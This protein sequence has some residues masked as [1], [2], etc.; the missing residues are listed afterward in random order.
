MPMPRLLARPAANKTFVNREQLLKVFEDACFAIPSDQAKLLVFYGIGGQG[1]TALCNELYR[2]TDRDHSYSFL[3]RCKLDLK[4]RSKTDPDLL[5]VWIRNGFAKAGIVF[6]CFDLAFTIAWD[7]TRGE[8]FMPRIESR[9]LARHKDEI[10]ETSVD[11]INALKE[12]IG[13]VATGIPVLGAMIRSIGGWTIRKGFESYLRK[14][15]TAISELYQDGELRTPHEL[16]ELL[17]WMLAQDLNHHIAT[18]PQ[19][20]FVLFIDEYERVF[21]EGGAEARWKEN[22]FDKHMRR[23]VAETD[24]LL[25]VFFSRERIPWEHDSDWQ[26]DLQ[27]AHHIVNGLSDK[28]A[29]QLLR[30]NSIEDEKLR[31]AMIE[32]ARETSASNAP[33][34]P[35]MLDLQVEHLYSLYAQ[36]S[37][38]EPD[39][40]CVASNEFEGRR[41]EL[42]E[43]LFRDYGLPLQVTLKRLCFARRFDRPAFEY[44]VRYFLTGLPLDAFETLA[45]MSF[46]TRSE[47]G[48]LSIHGVIAEAIRE[49][50]DEDTKQSSLAAL[51]AHYLNCAT[52]SSPNNIT[53]YTISSLFEA[54]Y[55]RKEIGVSG[56]VD[57]LADVT[58]PFEMASKYVACEQIWREALIFVENEL[59]TDHPDVV[60]CYLR[61]AFSLNVQKRLDAEPLI[62]RA[63]EVSERELG[64]DHPSTAK[65]YSCL[66]HSVVRKKDHSK[67]EELIR[68]ALD[69]RKRVLGE[70]HIDTAK[71]YLALAFTL[72]A[73]NREDVA[74]PFVRKALDIEKRL[75]GEDHPETATSYAVLA[76]NLI[77]QNRPQEAEKLNRKALDIRRRTLGENNPQTATSYIGL[78]SSLAKQ[79]RM[80]EA[81]PLI[82]KGLDIRANTLG[83]DH[84]DTATA[85]QSLAYNLTSQGGSVLVAEAEK[86]ICKA[87][88]IRQNILGECHPDTATAYV[89]LAQNLSIQGRTEEAET[90]ARKALDIRKRKLGN[91]HIDTADGYIGLWRNLT[92]QKKHKEAEPP[93][94]RALDIRRRILG[95]DHSETVTAMKILSANLTAQKQIDEAEVILRK[96]L[97]ITERVLGED[98]PETIKSY[99]GLVNILHHKSN[100]NDRKGHRN[101]NGRIGV[102]IS[103]QLD[104]A[105]DFIRGNHHKDAEVVFRTLMDTVEQELGTDHPC[106]ATVYHK[107]ASYLTSLKRFQEAEIL[108]RKALEINTKVY[109]T[110]HPE[111]VGG[112][113]ALAENLKTQVR[114]KEAELHYRKMADI[115]GRIYSNTRKPQRF[116]NACTLERLE[117]ARTPERQEAETLLLKVIKIR[118]RVLGDEHPDV[119]DAYLR[120]AYNLTIQ[121]RENEAEC[122]IRNA[123]AIRAKVLGSE[124]RDTLKAQRQLVINLKQQGHHDESEQENYRRLENSTDLLQ[125]SKHGVDISNELDHAYDLVRKGQR[126]KA[127]VIFRKLLDICKTSLGNDHPYTA[128]SYH[129]LAHH[130]TREKRFKESE[131]LIRRALEINMQAHGPTHPQTLKSRKALADNLKQQGRHKDAEGLHRNQE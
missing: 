27:D 39:A 95:E 115:K 19:D 86:L 128:G 17:P 28:D 113:K 68:K 29:D 16:S 121:K 71:S 38:I 52:V 62:L 34:Y 18:H 130:L 114:D 123:L 106:V 33:I 10:G 42:V 72:T 91:D 25:A 37:Q 74:E 75:L 6:P 50:L 104:L 13:E 26:A 83:E 3:R 8:Q 36:G 12:T 15:R 98:H 24:G 43:R 88:D 96:I 41:R 5:L 53:Q 126:D 65:A 109:G 117:N 99:F 48:N 125:T 56:Y 40:F 111:I 45:G 20:R 60:I 85:Y 124:H 131:P 14:T 44:V 89:I 55:L 84:P 30:A 73:Q 51:L 81:E 58:K 92:N 100:Q 57:W 70:D 77:E 112:L 67:A 94:R 35:L 93:I 90:F 54:A 116:E 87:L 118:K 31:V 64:V 66:A 7:A 107:F 47:E 82:R 32:G 101:E 59:G 22:P 120:L 23:F 79:S 63:L 105:H 11:L 76:H 9:W 80:T 61:L 122:Y 110:D 97:E 4:G 108:I 1:K 21:D 69:I 78:A 49:S 129:R 102:D 103:K 46:V 2:I 119:A 127:E